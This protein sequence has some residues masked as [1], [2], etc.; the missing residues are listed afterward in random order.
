MQAT[1]SLAWVTV[2]VAHCDTGHPKLSGLKRQDLF[3]VAWGDGC[4]RAGW[5]GGWSWAQKGVWPPACL[6]LGPWVLGA[7]Q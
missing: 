4:W 5:D 1:H 2:P 7:P 3:L 6:S